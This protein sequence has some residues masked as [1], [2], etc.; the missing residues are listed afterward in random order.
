V[1][2]VTLYARAKLSSVLYWRSSSCLFVLF[3]ATRKLPLLY[4]L[5]SICKNHERHYRDLF[6]KNLVRSFSV[7]FE[8]AQDVN[9]RASMYKLRTTWNSVFPFVILRQL[10]TTVREKLDPKWPLT[11]EPK[12]S[13]TSTGSNIH[14]NPNV[15]GRKVRLI[16]SEMQAILND[17]SQ[18]VSSNP[19]EDDMAKK[20]A[21]MEKELLRLKEEKLA[22]EIAKVREATAKISSEPQTKP[23][24]QVKRRVQAHC[25]LQRLVIAYRWSPLPRSPLPTRVSAT[26]S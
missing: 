1:L 6:A 11:P 25:P 26:T 24:P 7:A 21:E 5:D 23:Q 14:I 13:V 18:V 2:A 20:V 16:L 19:A 4:L 15:L 17:A 9:T 22:M 10:D 12:A 3:Q 8:S